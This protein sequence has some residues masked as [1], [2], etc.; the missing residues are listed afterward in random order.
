VKNALKIIAN[1]SIRYSGISPEGMKKQ[2]NILSEP[3]SQFEHFPNIS[4]ER[5]HYISLLGKTAVSCLLYIVTHVPIDRQRLGKHIPG[6]T[7]STPEGP[8]LLVNG[9]MSTYS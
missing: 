4:E 7:L 9:P 1:K 6:F 2:E 3:E 8:P 5:Y